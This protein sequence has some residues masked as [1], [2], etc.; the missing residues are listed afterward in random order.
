[1]G[2]AVSGQVSGL[3]GGRYRAGEARTLL[4]ALRRSAMKLR[5]PLACSVVELFMAG[6]GGGEDP[7]EGGE[8]LVR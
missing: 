2:W 7:R 6:W 3:Y 8:E 4:L 1:M 5:K